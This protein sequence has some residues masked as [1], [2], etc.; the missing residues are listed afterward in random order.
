MW[1]AV[2]LIFICLV[3]AL[4][5]SAAD[6]VYQVGTIVAVSPHRVEDSDSSF[7]RY[8]VSVKVG[9]T[10]YVVLYTPPLGTATVMYA[11]GRDL[12]VQVGEETLTANDGL[13]GTVQ[14]PILS[15]AT[16]TE[17]SQP[18]TG[19]QPQPSKAV[20][21][22]SVDVIG[23]TGVKDNTGGMLTV[24]SGK[25]HFASSKGD[26]AVDSAAVEDVITAE[27]SQRMIGGTA[28]TLS[29]LGPYGSGAFLSLFRT[30]IDTLTIQYRDADGGLHGIIFTMPQGTAEN[31]KRE[32]IAQGARTTIPVQSSP[33]S[34]GGA[35]V[36]Q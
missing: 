29:R 19:S 18:G 9:N 1:K 3:A 5:L 17:A 10:V 13:G 21:I 32:L 27:D 6:A 14:L 4:A 12:T 31:I 11:A 20:P 36:K 28:G 26:S 7:A 16:A 23:L 30:K 34:S 24:E 25:L 15:R 22:K 2:G 35:E 33:D 8:D